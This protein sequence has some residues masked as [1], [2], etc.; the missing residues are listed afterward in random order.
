M[1]WHKKGL[2]FEPSGKVDWISRYA[3][4]P[5]VDQISADR[6]KVFFAGRNEDNLSQVGYFTFD[7]NDPL[8]ILEISKTPVLE[9]GPL[10][11]FDDSAVIPSWIVEDQGIRYMYYIGWSQGK[12]VPYYSN[13]G[14]AISEDGGATFSKYSKGPLI[15]RNDIDP[16]MTA[17]PCVRIENGIWRLWYLSNTQ[18]T[19][20]SD[21]PM[22]RYHIKYAESTDGINWRREGTV[23]IDFKNEEEFA[24]ARPCVIHDDG[25]YKMWY[26]YRGD[27]YRIGYAESNDG[28]KWERQD[29]Q[30]GIDVSPSGWDS[31]MLEY[32]YVFSHSGVKYMLYNGN[33]YGYDGVGLAI[34]R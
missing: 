7:I 30:V 13:I 26:S 11:T 1:K 5:T 25:K 12:R 15:D 24:I 28:I 16:Y 23:C 27:S 17:S 32:A 10:G 2:I 20:G 34:E 22:P 8:D 9:L 4:I 29:Q 18:W 33:N 6:F 14:L 31:E 3:W 21:G 19:P